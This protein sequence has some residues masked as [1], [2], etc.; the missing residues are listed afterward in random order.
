MPCG[1]EGNRRSSVTLAMCHRLQWFIHSRFKALREVS[2]RSPSSWAMAHFGVAVRSGDR[3]P[4]L[5][6]ACTNPAYR[7]CW[8]WWG[9]DKM[10]NDAR[11]VADGDAADTAAAAC[12][13]DGQLTETFHS[14]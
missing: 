13:S 8:W 6:T 11:R 14:N 3:Y 7:C 12:S 5:E 2:T 10:T 4:T 9:G 1:W